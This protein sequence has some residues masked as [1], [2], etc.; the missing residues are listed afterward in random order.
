M[1]KSQCRP[2]Q[3]NGNFRRS[4]VLSLSLLVGVP[5]GAQACDAWVARVVAVE[6]LVQ[7]QTVAQDWQPLQAEQLICPGEVVQVGEHGRAALYLSNNTFA[8]LDANT[9]LQFPAQQNE[10]RFWIQLTRGIGHFISRIAQQFEVSTPYVNAVVDGTEFLVA[11]QTRGS[12]SVI[13][14]EVTAYNR[15]SRVAVPAGEQI[16]TASA[17]QDLTRLKVTPASLVEWAIFYPPVLV[18]SDLQ[19]QAGADRQTLES[20]IQALRANRIDQA[21]V[22][23]AVD[24]PSDVL[25]IARATLL[26][27]LGDVEAFERVLQPALSGDLSAEAHSLVAIAAIA[28][29]DTAD[30]LRAA[31]AA[32]ARAPQ[33]AAGW[34]ALSYAQQAA[35]DL[36]QALASARRAVEVQPD[37]VL[38]HLRQSEL[39]LALGDVAAARKVLAA[40]PD[41]A[42][43]TAEW[44]G[45]QGFAQLLAFNVQQAQIHFRKAIALDSAHPQYHLGLGLALLREG[46]LERGR[47]ELEYAVSLDPRRSVTRSYMGRAYFAGKRDAEA[48]EQWALAKQFDPNDPTPYFYTGVQ[49]LLVSDPVGAVQ[50]LEHAKDLNENRA[51]Y[52]G[53]QLLQSDAATRSATLA[54]AYQEA[55]YSQG[56]LLSGWEATRLDPASSEG[57]RLLADHYAGDP[58]Y[59]TARVSELFQSQIWAPLT[60]YPL[61]PQL[62]ETDLALVAGAGPQ[63]PGLNEYHSLFTRDGLYGSVNGY[64]AGD[65]TWGNDLTGSILA[66]PLAL[67]LGQY[68]FES[69]GWRDNADQTQDIYNGMLQWQVTTATQLQLEYRTLDWDRGDLAPRWD[70]KQSRMLFDNQE[71]ET[72]RVSL[73]HRFDPANALAVSYV[74]Q[75]FDNDQAETA[76]DYQ[77]RYR[78][79]QQPETWEVQ[80]VHK[81]SAW[82]WVYGAGRTD[83]D[84]D[85]RLDINLSLFDDSG[86]PTYIAID[87]NTAED[88][89]Q[90]QDDVYVYSYWSPVDDVLVEL[91]IT[92]TDLTL[93][94]DSA[95]NTITTT[96][97]PLLMFVDVTEESSL[98]NVDAGRDRWSP[99][100]GLTAGLTESLSLRVAAFRSVSKL[101]TAG[102]TLEPVTVAGFN[103]YF[104]D[105]DGLRSRNGA[106][107]L[108]YTASSSIRLGSSFMRRL[109][110][111]DTTVDGTSTEETRASENLADAYVN[112]QLS[113]QWVLL[114]GYRYSVI[115]DSYYEDA[116]DGISYA[117]TDGLPVE[118]RWFPGGRLSA[119]LKY[120]H[121]RHRFAFNDGLPTATMDEQNAN[122]VDVSVGYRLPERIG[123]LEAGIRNLTDEDTEILYHR[124]DGESLLGF[125]PAQLVFC[126]INLNF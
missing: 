19:P 96:E 34:L 73:T 47:R 15:R 57:H 52:R 70:S 105:R 99:K 108:D 62:A 27:Q 25:R 116:V 98:E 100:F 33:R 91:G 74:T 59:E 53:E 125:Y 43:G 110:D 122:V 79:D 22:L 112:V 63:T 94:G 82:R 104:A 58:R 67:S 21:L 5:G 24:Q 37:S 36:P 87:I 65:G 40:A 95:I 106:L 119:A 49:K 85:S 55:G 1:S 3:G 107:G 88:T 29:G 126:R 75:Q 20:A 51:P 84:I 11:A 38:A 121:Y 32:V 14:G 103:Q 61:Q 90:Q 44:E 46:D 31:Q 80:G 16:V 7:R 81:A 13:E 66:G 124:E 30:G 115:N 35:L 77:G 8:R 50:E 86:L 123:L 48:L 117:R 114:A 113:P 109:L 120:T 101:V 23:L 26:L 76:P 56:V 45:A 10:Q 9:V 60:A 68:H 71:R 64:G 54:R 6:G 102:Q 41:S 72:A 4:I 69:D 39:H 92:Y 97:I 111:G 28:R 17:D 93:Q 83:V 42:I 118:V 78:L 2:L 89:R 12:V 18:L